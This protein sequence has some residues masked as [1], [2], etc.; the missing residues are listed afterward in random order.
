LENIG[1]LDE[2]LHLDVLEMGLA[3][4]ARE[5]EKDIDK[6]LVMPRFF[7]FFFFFFFPVASLMPVRRW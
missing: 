7:F 2:G 6:V 3:V 1:H 4:E 5:R